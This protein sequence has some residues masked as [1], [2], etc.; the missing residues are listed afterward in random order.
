[1]PRLPGIPALWTIL[2]SGD[3]RARSRATRDGLAAIRVNVGGAA[4]ATGVLDAL[5]A[6][7][8]E[9]VAGLVGPA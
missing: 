6:L 4:I 3:V 8:A 9:I 2:R 5:V 7:S 1:M